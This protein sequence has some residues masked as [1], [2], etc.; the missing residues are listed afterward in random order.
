M[1]CSRLLFA[2]ALVLLVGVGPGVSS[3]TERDPL[4]VVQ[5]L[6]DAEGHGNLEAAMGY[7]AKEAVIVNATGRITADRNELTWFIDTEI[8]LRDVFD[9]DRLQA[10]GNRVTWTESAKAPFY[11]DLGVAPV[12]FAFEAIV[13]DGLI[14]TIVAHLPMSEIERIKEACM[15]R[16]PEPRLR[17]R[18]CSEFVQSIESHTNVHSSAATLSE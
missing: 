15:A 8:W 16:V 17:D 7:F 14:T 1:K 6:M 2:G 10:D 18:P 13:R 12:T 5:G 11:R 9:L 4:E 3:G